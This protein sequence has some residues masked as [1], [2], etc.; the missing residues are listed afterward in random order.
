MQKNLSFGVN[1]KRAIKNIG[2][3]HFYQPLYESI[4]NS[5]QA[6]AKE[7]KISFIRDESDNVQNYIVEDNGDGFTD[8]N[9]NSFLELW[10][11]YKASMGGLGS[12]RIL[13]LKVFKNIN[14]ESQTK[15]HKVIINFNSNFKANNKEYLNIVDNNSDIT[16]TITKFENLNDEFISENKLEKY[17]LDKI[18][19]NIFIKLLPMFIRFQGENKKFEIF[20]DNKLWLNDKI[21]EEKFAQLEFEHLSFFIEKD[22]SNFDKNLDSKSLK[23]YEFKLYYRIKKDKKNELQQF[24]GASDRN[25]IEFPNAVKI[26]KLENDWSAIFCLTSKYFE[27]NR[28][29]DARNKFIIGLGDNNSASIENPITFPEINQELSKKIEIILKDK[30]PKLEE[31]FRETQNKVVNKFPHLLRYVKKIEN[32]TLSESQIQKK[33]E[34]EF[35][36]ETKRVRVEV[37]N[38]TQN[39]KKGKSKF[40]DKKLKEITAHFTQTGVEQLADYIGYRQTIIDMLLE[41]YNKNSDIP[42]KE[43]HNLF[44][45]MGETSDTLSYHANNIWIF[46]DKFMSYSYSASDKTIAKIVKDVTGKDR[47]TIDENQRDKEPDLVMFY[48]DSKEKYKDVLLIEFKKLNG[49]IDDKEKAINQ[50]NRYPRYIDENINNIRNIYTYTILDIDKELEDG[51]TK[52]H[53]FVE[54]AFGD[55]ENKVSAYYKYNPAVKAHINV[56]SF[57]QL[58]EDANERNKVFLNILKEKFKDN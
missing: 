40:N 55:S 48:S 7:V 4:V 10:S 44:M 2:E 50:I 5:F 26:E 8:D 42:E 57:V 17:N 21:L 39:L 6:N 56:I 58:I 31:N 3:V 12:G 19:E 24:Y 14:I 43:I 18:K 27:E 34:K 45:P 23:R 38:F 29:A 25:I 36:K 37:E 54:N 32:L 9:I 49:N 35:F 1:L 28:V 41:I 47:A 52:E 30:F 11:D 15:E 20:I 53:G 13:C 51:L 33:A 46:D 22:L 16:R